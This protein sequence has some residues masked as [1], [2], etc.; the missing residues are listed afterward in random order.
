[1]FHPRTLVKRCQK[2]LVRGTRLNTQIQ[3]NDIVV[4]VH[5]KDI[6]SLRLSVRSPDGAVRI[7]APR[8]MALDSIRVFV[9]SKLGWIEKHQQRIR[10][11]PCIASLQYRD[12]ESHYL[13]G[14]CYALQVVERRAVPGVRVEDAELVLQ[15]RPGAD[16]AKRAAVL[17]AWYREQ[18]RTAL[19]ALVSQWE[20]R[21]GVQSSRIV[22]QRMKTKWGSC[23]IRTGSI[24]FNLEL[25]RKPL[26]CVEYVV[27][28][29]LVHLLEPSHNHRFKVLMSQYLPEWKML[30]RELNGVPVGE[31]E[32]EN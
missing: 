19:Q 4:D 21:I 10:A 11:R 20:A 29:E 24:R 22:I 12:G 2:S 7:S 5:H 18:L 30:R 14:E 27:V 28:H 8:G 15:V 1:M 23:N 26:A 9:Q 3:L 31:Q 16:V 13:W 25:A 32:R 6:R 17:D